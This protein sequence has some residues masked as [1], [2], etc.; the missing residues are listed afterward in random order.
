MERKLRIY[1]DSSVIGGCYDDEFKEW[2]NQLIDEFKSGL[3]I[4]VISE[5]IQAEI[6]SAP[7]EIQNVLREL[8]DCHCEILLE[9]E[10]SLELA[11]QYIASAILPKKFEND[12]RHIAV[13]TIN[14]V[15]MLVS[16]NFRHIVHFEKIQQFN[17]V[18]IK[19]GYK[20]IEIYSPR[21]VIN[22][23]V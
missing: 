5:L 10:E 21:E 11:Q 9:T 16:W 13:A 19:E 1:I 22:Y 2:S 8:L 4:P 14:N 18:N 17:S 7:Q 20:T 3:H 15:N 12:A 6:S 23:D